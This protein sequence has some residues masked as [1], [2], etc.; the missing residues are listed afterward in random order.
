MGAIAGA[1]FST[2]EVL[3]PFDLVRNFVFFVVDIRDF[4]P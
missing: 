2:V 4:P 3:R 1:D